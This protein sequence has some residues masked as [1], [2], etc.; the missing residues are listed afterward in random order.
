MFT[1]NLYTILGKGLLVAGC[2]VTLSACGGG[3]GFGQDYDSPFVPPTPTPEPTPGPEPTP[4]PAPTDNNI[5]PNSEFEEGEG[6][7]FTGWEKL[8]SGSTMTAVTSD[9]CSGRALQAVSAG[10][11][12]WSVQIAS[13]E[14]TTTIDAN[15]TATMWIKSSVADGIVRFSTSAENGAQ[16]GPDA[17][18]GTD[19]Q[20]VVW[21]FAPNS[22]ATKLVLDMGTSAATYIVDDVKFVPGDTPDPSSCPHSDDSSNLLANGSLEQG[23]GDD[24]TGWTKLNGAAGVTAT[25]AEVRTGSRAMQVVSTGGNEWDVQVASDRV[26]TVVDTSYTAS[27]WIKAAAAGGQVRFS[28]SADAGAKYQGLQDVGTDWTQITWDFTANDVATGV[29]LDMGASDATYYV[30]DISLTETPAQ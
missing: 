27:M 15:Y 26:T 12:P 20:Q 22:A 5:L 29:V 18:I 21:T 9:T 30:D 2:V 24:F 28:T 11:N 1:R 3:G 25:T 23:D 7:E 8:N 4:V 10:G 19:W 16:Y 13:P 17:T 6:D 14:A